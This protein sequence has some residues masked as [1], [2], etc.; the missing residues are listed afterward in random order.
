MHRIAAVP[1]GWD[2][3]QSGVIFLEQDPAPVVVLTAAD[4][5]LGAL[6]GAMQLLPQGFPAVRAANL[7]QLQQ[8]LSIDDYAEKVLRQARLILIRLLGGRAYWSYGLEVA[9]QV[10]AEE[11]S[12]LI[13]MPG[14]DRPDWD[15]VSHSTVSLAVADRVWR[16]W[17]EGGSENVAAS[18]S[19][20][21][22]EVLGCVYPVG[23]PQVL[24]RLGMYTPPTTPR[25]DPAVGILLYRAHVL[26]GNTEPVDQLTAA[27]ARR[28]LQPICLYTSG[29]Q[30]PNFPQAIRDHFG[31]QIEVLLNT[32]SFS[33]ARLDS[34][35]PDVSLWQALDVPVLQVILSGGSQPSW[36]ASR[37]GL[38]ARD[39]AM[40]VALPEV[41][42]RIVSRAVSFK[43][44]RQ[45]DPRLQT[46]VMAYEAVLDRVEFVADLA[47]NWVR[48][49]RT[50]ISERRL[51][52]ILAN[53][54]NR[55]G[56][57]AN[58]VGL[59]T[60]ASCGQIL[61]ALQATGYRIPW[62]P[63]SGDELITW[64]THGYTYDPLGSLR[65]VQQS[66]AAQVYREWFGQLPD[67]I[68]TQLIEQWGDPPPRDIPV[69]GLQLGQVF[70]GIQPPRGY[71]RDPALNYHAPDL[72]PPHEYL[73]FYL[74]LRQ[75]FGAQAIVHVGKHGNL[76]WLPGKGSALSAEC[77]P[78]IAL[79]PMPHFY[80]FIVNDPGEGSQAKRRAQAVIIDHLTPPLTRAELYGPL[81]ELERLMDEY[82]AAEQLDPG[83]CPLIRAQIQEI[84]RTEHL[85][86]LF[87]LQTEEDL[88]R[89][90][91]YLCELKESQI[92]DGLHILG[93]IPE[94]DQLIDLLAALARY[95]GNGQLG[96]TQAIAQDWGW[97]WDPLTA[98]LTDP[99]PTPSVKLR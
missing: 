29:L 31:G 49:R 6:A 76:E 45:V 26:A 33:L 44:V 3:S 56:R 23:D 69:V 9:K 84:A 95:P 5:D 8:P 96:L 79:G 87:N 61:Q 82:V 36:Q 64:L 47:T 94:G 27:L 42:G 73:A 30:E 19:F 92:R 98:N 38:G 2:P 55:D 58:G 20:L 39:L 53:Y 74:W 78:E 93:R 1:G 22:T 71:D 62:L 77:Y 13:V 7:L 12:H 70:V 18:L 32:T 14:D 24:P 41:D 63:Q 72:V 68:Q 43:A 51:A 10:V 80:P 97:E 40:N 48:L 21:A 28:G 65:P 75:V 17:L 59:D 37:R 66:L 99:W 11:G 54:P 83:R 50:P 89:L 35:Q 46:E 34:D 85:N 67:E 90:D 91:G 81:A 16:Y 15:L 52:L 25:G 60:P 57:L 88:N 86:E 4:T